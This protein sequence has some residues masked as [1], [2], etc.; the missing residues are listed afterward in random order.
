MSSELWGS[1]RACDRRMTFGE[2]WTHQNE[3]KPEDY[4]ADSSGVR[5][6]FTPDT[7]KET[8]HEADVE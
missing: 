2:Y 5:T 8:N 7:W 3:H 1:C 4:P 6:L